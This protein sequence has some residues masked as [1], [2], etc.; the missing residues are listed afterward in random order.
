MVDE[1]VLVGD[2]VAEYD[3]EEAHGPRLSLKLLGEEVRDRWGC[4][5]CSGPRGEP[6]VGCLAFVER[7]DESGHGSGF[8]FCEKCLWERLQPARHADR[9]SRGA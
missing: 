1:L 9:L 5:G 6:T 7:Y 3:P 8:A 4:S 2:P